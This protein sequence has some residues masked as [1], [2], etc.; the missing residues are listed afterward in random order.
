MELHGLGTLVNSVGEVVPH[1][2]ELLYPMV[3]LLV[4]HY[5]VEV[6]QLLDPVVVYGLRLRYKALELILFTDVIMH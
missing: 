1:L 4:L 5:G 6:L 2:E 3:D